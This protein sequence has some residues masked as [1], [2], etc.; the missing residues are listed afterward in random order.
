MDARI[1][2]V[3][4]WVDDPLQTAD[5]YQRVVGLAGVRLDAF[6]AGKAPFPS[7]RVN[8]DSIIDL[9]AR[10]AAPAVDAMVGTRPGSGHPLN[11]LCLAMTRSEFE[12]LLRRLEQHGVPVSG[13][14]EHSFGARGEAP[15]AFY[16]HDPDGNTLEARYYDD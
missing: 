11:H 10:S 13:V 7:L 4:L 12:A 14:M 15:R 3:V 6:R 5:F 8:G 16:F 2:H 1:D 9:M